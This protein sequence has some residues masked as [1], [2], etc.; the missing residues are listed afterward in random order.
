MT[1]FARNIV[2]D[3]VEKRL[4]PVAVALLAALVAVPVLLGSGGEATT[5]SPAPATPSTGT[6]SRAE[7]TLDNAAPAEHLRDG[8][9]RD[10]FATSGGAG[11]SSAAATT[12]TAATSTATPSAMAAAASGTAATTAVPTTSST[13]AV[14]TG[15]G[16][17][18]TTSAPTTV[19]TT[20]STAG[21]SGTTV[22]TDSDSGSTPSTDGVEEPKTSATYEV[23]VRFG[24]TLGERE[25]LRNVARLTALPSPKHPVV[26]LLGVLDGGRKAVFTVSAK[27][28][29]SGNGDCKPSA[30]DCKTVELREGDAEYLHVVSA[31]EPDAWYYLKLLHID[32]DRAT[33]AQAAVASVRHSRAGT[34]V[35]REAGAS[36][37]AYRYLPG[38]GVLVRAKHSS[39]GGAAAGDPAQSAPLRPADEQPGVVAWRS[40]KPAAKR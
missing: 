7:V 19:T 32:S 34:A 5:S 26:A 6:A 1:A 18:T 8:R 11:G 35:V 14:T 27:A 36:V 13:T 38:A 40:V 25:T 9:L 2:S 31:G 10:P 23:S 17:T 12:A 37:R 33:A 15:G 21:T 22:S 4:W 20:P 30:E 39:V 24:P 28:T 29:A 3:L 16:L